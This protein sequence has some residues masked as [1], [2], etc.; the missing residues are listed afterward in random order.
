MTPPSLSVVVTSRNDNHG[1]NMMHRFGHFFRGFL[2][3]ARRFDLD[4][5][6]II[7]EWNPPEGPRLAEV[8]PIP[9]D[10]GPVA[11]RFIEVPERLHHTFPNRFK[12]PLFQM[13]AKN[14]GIRR[15]AGRFVLSTCN[16]LIF[17]DALVWLLAQ[18]VLEEDVCYRC[19]RHDLSVRRVPED[20]GPAEREAFCRA[21]VSLINGPED[22][23]GAGVP[24]F[25][26]GDA[27]FRAQTRAELVRW[28]DRCQWPVPHTNACGDFTL[29]SRAAWWAMRGYPEV[30]IGDM[31]VDGLAVF[32]ARAMGLRQVLLGEPAVLWHIFH[33]MNAAGGESLRKRLE[34]R[35]GLDYEEYLGWCMAMTDAGD[36]LNPNGA[37]WGLGLEDLRETRFG[38][39]VAV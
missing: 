27:A 13:I 26:G 1:E 6:L 3:Q 35:P 29:M 12:I 30:P 20:L 36:V 16:D 18:D 23:H 28:L 4:A 8:L 15:A 34:K 24:S 25:P 5:E 31:Y 10:L 2:D 22:R 19:N 21:H 32:A 14:V 38:D 7:V 9:D 37:A 17:S 33:G 11:L 39:R